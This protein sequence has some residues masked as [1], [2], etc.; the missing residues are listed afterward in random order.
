MKTIAFL[1]HGETEWNREKRMQGRRDISLTADAKARFAAL[2]VPAIFADAS[3]HVSPLARARETAAALGLAPAPA[4]ALIETDW[5]AWEGKTLAELRAED[6]AAMQANEGRGLYLQPPGGE[7]P[8]DVQARVLAWLRDLPT[9]PHGAVTHKGVI[10]A[11]MAAAY[12]WD[13][14]GKAPLTLQWDHLHV[15]EMDAGGTL[16]PAEMNVPLEARP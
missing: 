2:R 11:V 15:F 14:T 6:P 5:G 16:T 3:W 13:M 12:D 1:R 10:R 4:P 9:G 7:R 8:F